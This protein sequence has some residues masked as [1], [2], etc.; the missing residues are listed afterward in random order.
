MNSTSI[1]TLLFRYSTSNLSL[2]SWCQL[3]NRS[4]NFASGACAGKSS[5]L[6]V[7]TRKAASTYTTEGQ[8]TEKLLLLKS[9]NCL[10]L[11]LVVNI[12]HVWDQ[13]I[14]G[15]VCC[16]LKD[17]YL[18]CFKYFL[19]WPFVSFFHLSFVP[20]IPVLLLFLQAISVPF[21]ACFLDS[22]HWCLI[23]AG[24]LFVFAKIF[25]LSAASILFWSAFFIDHWCMRRTYYINLLLFLL[26]MILLHPFILPWLIWFLYIIHLHHLVAGFCFHFFSCHCSGVAMLGMHFDNLKLEGAWGRGHTASPTRGTTITPLSFAFFGSASWW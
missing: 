1:H 17:V 11:S 16:F 6:M 19:C 15:I 25:A 14:F 4:F 24:L 22:Q 21:L 5:S 20:W 3:P 26:F 9:G 10:Q 23:F 18:W 12:P 13:T 2:M 8:P 7:S